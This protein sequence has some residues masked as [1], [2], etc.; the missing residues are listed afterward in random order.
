MERWYAVLRRA[1]R[2]RILKC[3]L[4]LEDKGKCARLEHEFHIVGSLICTSKPSFVLERRGMC[5][6]A[7]DVLSFEV[8]DLNIVSMN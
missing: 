2:G 4:S 1:E 7:G 5:K 6:P 8:Y 3:D